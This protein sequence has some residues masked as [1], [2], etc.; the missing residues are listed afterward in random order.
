MK[1]K[2]NLYSVLLLLLGQAVYGQTVDST[3][4]SEKGFFGKWRVAGISLSGAILNR[5]DGSSSIQTFEKISSSSTSKLKLAND[6]ERIREQSEFFINELPEYN[7]NVNLSIRAVLKPKKFFKGKLKNYVEI[8]LGLQ[9]NLQYYDVRLYGESQTSRVTY[10]SYGTS[11]SIDTKSL[12]ADALVTLQTPGFFS[13]FSFYSGL[14]VNGGASFNTII[15][16]SAL[17]ER[18]GLIGRNFSGNKDTVTMVNPSTNDFY[19]PYASLGFYF[20]VGLKVNISRH[21]NLFIEYTI[22][23]S[24]IVFSNF[25]SSSSWFRG[26]GFG[27]RFKFA[28]P[29]KKEKVPLN[30]PAKTP[31]PFY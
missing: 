29:L 30:T 19:L 21:S 2:K 11:Y 28:K 3:S 9:Y 22:N 4:I 14:G 5:F 26:W 16:S 10:K 31:E 20:P 8:A 7:S 25:S 15:E 23:R 1:L 13:L 27:Y 12:N 24:N 17:V 6:L 18:K